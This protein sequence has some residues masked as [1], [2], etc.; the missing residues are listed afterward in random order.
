MPPPIFSPILRPILPSY[1]PPPSK[2]HYHTRTII[3]SAQIFCEMDD[4]LG[5]AGGIEGT[6]G[7]VDDFLVGDEGGDTVCGEDHVCV[8]IAFFFSSV[9]ASASPPSPLSP[10][11]NA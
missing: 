10:Y 1:I 6:A 5:C 3:G 11:L 9:T 4:R 2:G 7:E 8:G